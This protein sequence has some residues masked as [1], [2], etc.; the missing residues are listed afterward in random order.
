MTPPAKTRTAVAEP[1]PLVE[2][3]AV[4]ELSEPKPARGPTGFVKVDHPV[5]WPQACVVCQSAKGP[6]VDTMHELG[7]GLGRIYVCSQCLGLMALEMGLVEGDRMAELNQ[8]GDR[9]DEQARTITQRDA[10][11]QTQL[12]E[13][14]ARARKIEALEE[15]LAQER[16]TVQTQRHL[17]ELINEN[18]KQ[19]L[20]S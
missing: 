17:L 15:L 20:A 9:L 16:G 6:L 3:Q 14:A 4:E 8:A 5:L 11:L 19:G 13:L 18:A 12:G 1:D 10:A 2:E 7:A